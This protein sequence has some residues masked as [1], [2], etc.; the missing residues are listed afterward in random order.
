M[1]LKFR[2]ARYLLV[3]H[4]D[5]QNMNEVKRCH[6]IQ[7]TLLLGWK[8]MKELKKEKKEKK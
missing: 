7:S 1:E 5:E 2:L 3:I 8:I 6:K 4:Q